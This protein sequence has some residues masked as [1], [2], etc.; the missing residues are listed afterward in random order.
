MK[1]SPLRTNSMTASCDATLGGISQLDCLLCYLVTSAMSHQPKTKKKY[2][3]TIP[4]WSKQSIRWWVQMYISFCL[5]L[6][7]LKHQGNRNQGIVMGFCKVN[8]AQFKTLINCILIK[9]LFCSIFSHSNQRNA[10]NDYTLSIVIGLSQIMLLCTLVNQW[11]RLPSSP[12]SEYYRL[13]KF[14]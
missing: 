4:S 6:S 1:S 3:I 10:F 12:S 11:T 5:T 8:D 2:W 7:W 9:A 13:Q 14:E